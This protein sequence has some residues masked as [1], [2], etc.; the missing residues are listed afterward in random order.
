DDS[1]TSMKLLTASVTTNKL[2]PD[3]VTESKILTAAVT[4]SK[5]AD[6]A[7][8]TAKILTAAVTTSKLADDAITE[9]KLLD[10]AV[11]TNK[12]ASSYG[13]LFRVSGGNMTSLDT[14]EVGIGIAVPL[15]TLHVEC[16]TANCSI[17]MGGDGSG[18]PSLVL[19]DSFGSGTAVAILDGFGNAR[20]RAR[21][22]DNGTVHIQL[23]GSSTATSWFR[24]GKLG[25]GKATNIS[26]KLHI[27]DT[28]AAD[29]LLIDESE[30]VRF[31][32]ENG[33]DVGIG[34]ENPV[35]SLDVT[36]VTGTG[37]IV[38]NLNSNSSG[39]DSCL[40]YTDNATF[41]YGA[42]T[43]GD[44]RYEL[45]S[46]LSTA[47][48]GTA[49]FTVEQG[50]N[51]GIGTTDPDTLFHVEGGA[52][53]I[54]GASGAA[55][56]ITLHSDNL[57]DGNIDVALIRKAD[58]SDLAFWNNNAARLNIQTD[59]TIIISDLAG[60]YGGGSA[61]VCVNDAGDIFASDAACP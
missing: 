25:V 7:I 13:S 2:A 61:F 8:S 35:A 1:V 9:A 10:D 14:G 46:A 18:N 42:C 19:K 43:M 28:G 5:V 48:A 32:V 59:G 37:N 41:N 58:S 12:L 16:A 51:V 22:Y 11:T 15:K 31:I 38:L 56:D 24:D 54:T 26:A 55:A 34:I 53:R 33:G 36:G 44:G 21:L 6:D 23:D 27:G 29:L 17:Q 39:V 50:G 40:K 3:A 4:T 49:R 45:R 47:A 30:T 52:L 20:G 57:E 60:T